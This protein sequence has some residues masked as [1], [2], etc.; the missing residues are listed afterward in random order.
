MVLAGPSGVGKSSIVDRLRTELPDLH[1][2][3]SATT[4]APRE[5]EVEGIHYHF[6]SREEFDRL[7]R[8]DELLEWAEVHGG[9]QRSGTPRE[10]VERELAAGHPVLVEV[11]LQ[12]ARS[13]KRAVPESVT[14]FVE[15]P[16]FEELARRLTDRGT[17]TA[18]ARERRLRTA[19]EEMAARSEFDVVVVND[20]VQAVVD[21]L[22]ELLVA[23]MDNT[24]HP[25][26][27]VSGVTE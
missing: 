17:E 13:V 21:R 22:V 27:T 16:S 24:A 1:F 18:A 12:G 2:S 25:R 8:S 23:P 5:G 19:V 7:I 14:V 4:R 6:V 10:P 26:S 20:E 3:V 15:P 9:L 11:D